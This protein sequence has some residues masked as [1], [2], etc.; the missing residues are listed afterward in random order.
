MFRNKFELY[1]FVLISG[2]LSSIFIVCP[3][4]N[5]HCNYEAIQMQKQIES[6]KKFRASLRIIKEELS[7]IRLIEENFNMQGARIKL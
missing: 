4:V 1:R 2:I 3:L 5:Y 7:G 6:A